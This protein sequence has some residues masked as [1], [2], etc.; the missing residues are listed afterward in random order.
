M[1]VHPEGSSIPNF[2]SNHPPELTVQ[3][4]SQNISNMSGYAVASEQHHPPYISSQRPPRDPL[5]RYYT[6]DTLTQL[7]ATSYPESSQRTIMHNASYLSEYD[8]RDFQSSNVRN[9]QTTGYTH[10]GNSDLDRIPSDH[11]STTASHPHT[12]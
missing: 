10:L 8:T 2:R 1:K 4:A 5:S 11:I 3:S 7:V 6:N 9:D 12:P